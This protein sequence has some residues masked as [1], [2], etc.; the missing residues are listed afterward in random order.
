MKRDLESYSGLYHQ[1]PFEPVMIQYRR[2]KTLEMTGDISGLKILEVGCGLSPAFEWMSAYKSLTI[3][4]PSDAFYK[5]ALEKA[6]A[7][8]YKDSIFM[9]PLEAEACTLLSESP[10]DLILVNSLLHELPN[11]SELL[12]KLKT[13]CHAHT[14][15]QVNVPNALSFHR[16]LAVHMGL[17]SKPEE[18]SEYNIRFQQARVFTPTSLEELCLSCGFAV[19]KSETAFIKPFTH[20]QMQEL[21]DNKIIDTKVIDGLMQ[22]SKEMPGYGAEIFLQLGL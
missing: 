20:Q 8:K 11:P 14:R 6:L 5:L 2:Q 17:I 3:L 16:L 12:L 21:L 9:I 15:I 22:M 13:W 1:Q 18:A 7:S 19:L 10:F 4:E